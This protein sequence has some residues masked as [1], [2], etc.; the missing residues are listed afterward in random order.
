M[1]DVPGLEKFYDLD[2]TDYAGYY[3]D[4]EYPWDLLERIDSVIENELQP[5]VD[6]EV[7]PDAH[8]GEDVE[9]GKDTVVE[10]G[11]TIKGPAIIGNGCE[12]RSGA[13]IR[14]KV[15]VGNGVTVGN[16]A[17]LK[18]SLVHDE[19][20]IPHFSYVGD[21]VIGWKGH[22]GAGVKVSNLKVN[23]ESVVVHLGEKDID[24]GLRKFGCLLGDKV[25]VGCNSVLNPGT[26]V[27]K[28]TLAT[29][30]TSLSGYYP[31]ERFVKLK[32]SIE[33]VER[34]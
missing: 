34:R 11:A 32:Q 25:E 22:L 28:R 14:G 31:P 1:E 27:G 13:Y 10:A 29:S 15:V 9:L 5:G 23:R 6:G 3:R 7:S 4:L 2:K 26:L 24:T 12:I 30:N 21:S 17:E 19:A 16:S 18:R 8:V 33:I 20:E